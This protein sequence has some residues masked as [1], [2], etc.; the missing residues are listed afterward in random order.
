L[1]DITSCK[2][3]NVIRNTLVLSKLSEI[4][5]SGDRH[6]LCAETC[7]VTLTT[8]SSVQCNVHRSKLLHQFLYKATPTCFG[9][10]IWPASDSTYGQPQTV[11]I[12]WRPL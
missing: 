1:C 3:S 12:T 2:T 11:H 7:D 9:H 4:G 5:I 8:A 6:S 10:Y